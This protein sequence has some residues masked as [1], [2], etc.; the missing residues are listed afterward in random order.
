MQ[1]RIHSTIK[2]HC[3]VLLTAKVGV[4]PPP[5]AAAMQ[6]TSSDRVQ[7]PK[8]DMR[9]TCCRNLT[10]PHKLPCKPACNPNTNAAD[11]KQ[12][13]ATGSL[14]Y[15]GGLARDNTKKTCMKYKPNSSLCRVNAHLGR[16]DDV[17]HV[18][19]NPRRVRR[20]F[21]GRHV[22]RPTIAANHH[23]RIV[24]PDAISV[25]PP[26]G[27]TPSVIMAAGHWNNLRFSATN[28]TL[29]SSQKM[30]L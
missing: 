27:L 10:N 16:D 20:V 11:M 22:L 6:R 1:R 23:D 2:R 29:H 4:P 8:A 25:T 21:E 13:R 5:S 28:C 17:R 9:N 14:Q 26:V 7:S 30:S 19:A 3:P 15:L 18:S 12:C 24:D